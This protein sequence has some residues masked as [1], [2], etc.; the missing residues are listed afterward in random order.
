[1]APMI[2]VVFL[3]LIFFMSVSTFHQLETEEGIAL[4][5]ADES[6]SLED[7]PQSLMINV[8]ENGNIIVNQNNY[9]PLQLA[10]LLKE[11]TSIRPDQ[12]VIIRAD[13]KVPHGK[14]AEI[15]SACAAAGIWNISFAT[16]QEPPQQ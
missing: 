10:G 1:M 2:D 4:P 5:V 11:A 12:A 7:L 13:K 6:K 3:L 9:R 15:L 14:V 16:Y 8:E